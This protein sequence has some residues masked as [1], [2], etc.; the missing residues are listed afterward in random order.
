MDS[1]TLIKGEPARV[2]PTYV[3]KPHE[4]AT[5]WILVGVAVVVVLVWLLL[6]D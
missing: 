5:V 3:S 6:K 4:R 1:F 2:T